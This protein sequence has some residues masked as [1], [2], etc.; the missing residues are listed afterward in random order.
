MI[1]Y[2]CW[3]WEF[4]WFL[5]KST[6]WW[7]YQHDI[8]GIL[9]KWWKTT[10]KTDSNNVG[11]ESSMLKISNLMMIFKNSVGIFPTN[12]TITTIWICI[13]RWCVSK[14]TDRDEEL[15]KKINN[16]VLNKLTLFF[17]GEDC[18]LCEI[19][20]HYLVSLDHANS[21]IQ[22]KSSFSTKSD[23]AGFGVRAV[24]KFFPP[25]FFLPG[26]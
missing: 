14:I 4:W 8:C 24:G 16:D 17:Y 7:K 3:W 9:F 5:A 1:K 20:G 22:V 19:G 21:V 6:I 26:F 15:M 10:N 18:C 25:N 2:M 11:D 12:N 23:M 13:H